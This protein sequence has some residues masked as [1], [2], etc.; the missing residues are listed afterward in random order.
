DPVRAT[1]TVP[2]LGLTVVADRLVARAAGGEDG[3]IAVLSQSFNRLDAAERTQLATELHHMNGAPLAVVLLDRST[4]QF[5]NHVGDHLWTV[6]QA[7][8]SLPPQFQAI[9]LETGF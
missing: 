7:I 6:S 8:L 4:H 5:G 9:A 2:E 1:V 3:L